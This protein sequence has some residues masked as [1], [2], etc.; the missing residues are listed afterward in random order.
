MMQSA[1]VSTE[2]QT[3]LKVEMLETPQIPVIPFAVSL[4]ASSLQSTDEPE[5]KASA[6]A[7]VGD[8]AIVG[9]IVLLNNSVTIWVGWG[10]VDLYG[11][12]SAGS[13]N[14]QAR[15]SFGKGTTLKTFA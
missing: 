3:P 7:M 12:S 4:P 8:N 14:D 9:S 10:N 6:V 5:S 1:Q 13:E 2:D 11:G 15:S